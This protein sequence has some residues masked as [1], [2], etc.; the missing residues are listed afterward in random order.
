[1]HKPKLPKI[2]KSTQMM[3]SKRSPEILTSIGVA[4]IFTT[5]VLAVKAT[6]KALQMIEKE[7]EVKGEPLT[8]KE[9]VKVTW[10]CYIPAVITGVTS[11]ACVIGA[12]NVNTK[13][14]AALAAAYTLS[15][16]AFAEYKEKVVE[17]IGKEQE[18]VVREAV[19]KDKLEKN[20]VKNSEI[21]MTGR[22]DDI[23]YDALTGRY[24]K[25][26]IE[27]LKKVENEINRKMRN[28]NYIS[29]NE[30][31]A[32][33]GLPGTK[34]GDNVGWNIDRGYVD[35]EFSAMLTEDGQP[36]L[37]LDYSVEPTY[38]YWR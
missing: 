33:I 37:V 32:E 1:M 36:C 21:I 22:G 14:N 7:T 26:D 4:G 9:T 12:N 27:F 16:T 5:A 28:E 29:L 25:S 11:A 18:Q 19:I 8:K 23:C 30:F 34:I 13:R 15:E 17:T 20:P 35:L 38:D 3:I 10:K 24:F 31:Y 2:I 6:P